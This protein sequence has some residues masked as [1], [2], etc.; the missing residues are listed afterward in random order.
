MHPLCFQKS[1]N[2]GDFQIDLKTLLKGNMISCPSNSLRSSL[3]F[4]VIGHITCSSTILKLS[5][6]TRFMKVNS[7]KRYAMKNVGC[8]K[9]TSTKG[10]QYGRLKL[11]RTYTTVIPFVQASPTSLAQFSAMSKQLSIQ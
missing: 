9:L 3:T 5:N 2:T 1:Y 7:L 10:C 6:N 11:S 8:S 4:L